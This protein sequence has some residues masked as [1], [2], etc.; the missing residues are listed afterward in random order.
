MTRSFFFSPSFLVGEPV[1]TPQKKM[2]SNNDEVLL[3]MNAGLQQSLQD[4]PQYIVGISHSSLSTNS[5]HRTVIV[6]KADRK[7]SDSSSSGNP[8]P[9]ELTQVCEFPVALYFLPSIKVDDPDPLLGKSQTNKISN[10]SSC[11]S[12]ETSSLHIPPFQCKDAWDRPCVFNV[13]YLLTTRTNQRMLQ[14]S[15]SDLVIKNDD[16][17]SLLLN[18]GKLSLLEK[19][20]SQSFLLRPRVIELEEIEAAER[21]RILE[22][23]SF[24]QTRIRDATYSYHVLN[25][26]LNGGGGLCSSQIF[27]RTLT[28]KCITIP[29]TIGVTTYQDVIHFIRESEGIP[30]QQQLLIWAGMPVA[31]H[32]LVHNKEQT[33]NL[34]LRLSAGRPIA[35]AIGC[36]GSY[37]FNGGTS[38]MDTPSVTNYLLGKG[39]GGTKSLV[40]V[41]TVNDLLGNWLWMSPFG[42]KLAESEPEVFSEAARAKLLQN[43]Y[44]LSAYEMLTVN[45]KCEAWPTFLDRL[46][47]HLRC[48]WPRQEARWSWAAQDE[49]KGN[50]LKFLRSFR[51]AIL[52]VFSI[53]WKDSPLGRDTLPSEVCYHIAE[54]L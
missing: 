28:G 32:Q 33:C 30:P 36:N 1:F 31:A 13:Q 38:K 45:E 6:A 37:V 52:C 16:L 3:K 4:V 40:R 9:P 21:L 7:R 27:V 41:T 44:S 18:D 14:C 50:D 49:G 25:D 20:R 54:F 42:I 43:K 19:L 26:M 12:G 34:V 35:S 46:Q 48:L 10:T 17:S 24:E 53:K 2:S 8:V 5:N 39:D 47:W 11:I 51:Q 23:W 15:S 22:Q 29:V